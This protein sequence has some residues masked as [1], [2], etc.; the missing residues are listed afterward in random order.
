MKKTLVLLLLISSMYSYCQN[1]VYFKD[2]T[3][4][5]VKRIK[6][7]K[8]KTYYEDFNGEVVVLK[9]KD[10]EFYLELSLAEHI[11]SSYF[12]IKDGKLIWQKVFL[13]DNKDLIGHFSKQVIS[14]ISKDNLQQVGN[15]MSFEIKED[16]V[17]YKK[18]GGTWSNTLAHL[19]VP[20]SYL[21]VI[22]FKE[23]KYRVTISF[24]KSFFG[25]NI[26]YLHLSD[27]SLKNGSLTKKKIVLRGLR[28]LNV[29]FVKK[30]LI[31]NNEKDDW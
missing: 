14:N 19:N 18:Y 12:K 28:F 6:V 4:K 10:Y 23:N 24:I 9:K 25:L 7:L 13:K 11:D 31:V 15:R 1:R 27:V 8:G 5:D 16:K 21:V 20:I 26:G 29:H 30:F 17:E 2:N 3:F 22:D